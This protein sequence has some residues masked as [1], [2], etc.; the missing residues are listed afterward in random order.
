MKIWKIILKFRLSFFNFGGAILN[1]QIVKHAKLKEIFRR[2]LLRQRRR[3]NTRRVRKV[4]IQL[5]ETCT[6]LSIYKSDAVN[7]LPVHKFIFQHSRWH[8]P[9][10][11]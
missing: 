1:D 3:N 2:L 8:C 11:Y 7:E 10:V 9:N 6:T 4:K 5:S